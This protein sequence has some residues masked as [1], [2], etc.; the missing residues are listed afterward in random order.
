MWA[1]LHNMGIPRQLVQLLQKWN[2]SRTAAVR[3]N[4]TVSEPFPVTKGL[5]QGSVLSPLLFNLYI[6]TLNRRLRQAGY[7]PLTYA[8]DLAAEEA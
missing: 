2:S 7:C 3:V 8:D 5:P 4:G 6:E 1:L